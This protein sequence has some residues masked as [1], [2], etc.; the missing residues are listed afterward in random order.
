MATA[1]LI[2]RAAP[3]AEMKKGKVT[4]FLDIDIDGAREAYKTARDFVEA[5]NLT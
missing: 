5:T 4:C 1:T 3:Q 2:R